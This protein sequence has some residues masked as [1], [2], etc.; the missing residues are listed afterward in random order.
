MKKITGIGGVFVKCKD[1]DVMK[2]WYKTYLGLDAGDYGMTFE[3][4]DLSKL[5]VSGSTTWNLFS[6]DTKHFDPSTQNFMINYTV[7]NIE[8]LFEELKTSGVTILDTIQSYDYGKFVHI[9]DIE[10]NKIE[11]WE[12]P[13]K[14]SQTFKNNN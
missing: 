7:E 12:P 14:Q 1:V 3:W 2:Q 4:C 13:N 8:E 5:A 6:K 11:L 10:G 9:L